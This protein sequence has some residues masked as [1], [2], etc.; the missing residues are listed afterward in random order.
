ME[1]AWGPALPSTSWPTSEKQL[2]LSASISS[3]VNQTLPDNPH[4]LP[5]GERVNE[6]VSQ[7]LVR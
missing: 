3:L 4:S 5:H 2:F 7:N 6:N 1:A